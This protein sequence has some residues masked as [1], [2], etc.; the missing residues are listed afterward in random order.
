[1]GFLSW[2]F[3]KEA[4]AQQA[5][6]VE[7]EM[8]EKKEEEVTVVP[9]GSEQ[10]QIL[11]DILSLLDILKTEIEDHVGDEPARLRT[12]KNSATQPKDLI[13]IMRNNIN[14]LINGKKIISSNAQISKFTDTINCFCIIVNKLKDYLI[15]E[16]TFNNIGRKIIEFEKSIGVTESLYAQKIRKISKQS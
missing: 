13:K 2:I 10:I 8:P 3:G 1:M 14:E 6:T 9:L 12:I 16:N 11:E 5:A 4:P 15:L 7:A